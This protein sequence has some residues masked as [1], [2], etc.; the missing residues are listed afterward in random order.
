MIHVGTI[1]RQAMLKLEQIRVV[2]RPGRWEIF[3]EFLDIET[4]NKQDETWFCAVQIAKGAAV[5]DVF[6]RLFDILHYFKRK[7]R[8]TDE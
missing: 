1:R 2:D 7:A 8:E 4:S 3:F 5:F 6:Q